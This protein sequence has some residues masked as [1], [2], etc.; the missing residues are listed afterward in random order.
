MTRLHSSNLRD[1]TN[2]VFCHWRKATFVK[3]NLFNQQF[4]SVCTK[5]D[6]SPLPTFSQSTIPSM[7]NITIIC[8]R[9][10]KL[11]KNMKPHNAARSYDILGMLLEETTNKIAPA[12][13][14]F[15]QAS[16]DQ[17][18]VPSSWKHAHV[19]SL[20]KKGTCAT[21]A[22]YRP[23]L[24]TSILCKLCENVIQCHHQ[25]FYMLSSPHRCMASG[26]ADHV[27]HSWSS[28]SMI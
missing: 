13:T 6:D 16:L 8:P 15:F 2:S 18:K 12:V 27:R 4:T 28:P 24:L 19:V 26:N 14:L 9:I 11:L 23:I 20:L 22:N 1:T 5:E 21:A 7:D 3:A 17:G 10:I 25:S